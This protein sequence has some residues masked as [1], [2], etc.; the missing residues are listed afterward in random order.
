MSNKPYYNYL[1][2]RNLVRSSAIIIDLNDTIFK[3]PYLNLKP[4]ADLDLQEKEKIFDGQFYKI[5]DYSFNPLHKESLSEMYD[6]NAYVVYNPKLTFNDVRNTSGFQKLWYRILNYFS[7][8]DKLTVAPQG[9]IVIPLTVKIIEGTTIPK[10]DLTLKEELL[11]KL[12]VVKVVH[13]KSKDSNTYAILY[14]V[15]QTSIDIEDL[16]YIGKLKLL[17]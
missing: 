3:H 7:H 4:I 10:L 15:T 9:T 16:S 12:V 11:D 8:V 5:S 1:E 13:S 6:M 2:L 14:N 17:R